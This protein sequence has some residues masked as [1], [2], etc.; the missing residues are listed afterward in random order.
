ML[1]PPI[2]LDGPGF[3]LI[4][5]TFGGKTFKAS[6]RTFAHLWETQRRLDIVRPGAWIRV[7]QPCYNTGVEQSKGTHDFD[8]TLDVEI[9]GWDDWW[10]EQRFLR[11]CGWADWVRYPPTFSWH[12]HM[13]SLGYTTRVG[14]YVPGQIDDYYA[15]AMGL[16]G[17]HAA[18]S[19]DTWHPADIDSTVFRFPEWRT[20]QESNMPLNAE[21]RQFIRDAAASAAKASIE[22]LLETDISPE[23]GDN[24]EIVTVRVALRRAGST[25]SLI[26]AARDAVLAKFLPVTKV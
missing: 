14:I 3:E 21:D 7:I 5:S 4:T 24:G 11:E 8:A 17:Q 15:H 9:V 16:A 6:R 1:A 13:V 2:L 18:G 10:A 19:D 22:A 26:R 23:T 25:P 12:H 20:E